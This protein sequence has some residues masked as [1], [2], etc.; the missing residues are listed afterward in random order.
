MQR[1]TFAARSVTWV[2]FTVTSVSGGTQNVG[3]AEIR[4]LAPA[5]TTTPPPAPTRTDVTGSASVTASA[6]NPAD[7]QTAVKAVD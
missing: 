2:R 5:D 3:L 6:E 4:A 7:G 1:I